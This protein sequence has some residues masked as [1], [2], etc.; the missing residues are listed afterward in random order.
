MCPMTTVGTAILLL[1]ILV[2]LG[3]LIAAILRQH[4][5]ARDA[6]LVECPETES[7]VGVRLSE[8]PTTAPAVFGRG[9]P[10]HVTDCTHWPARAD[11]AQTCVRR[12]CDAQGGTNPGN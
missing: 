10:A 3:L 6:W 12:P 2:T 9:A 11:C 1:S 7:Y 4:W 5:L 8:G